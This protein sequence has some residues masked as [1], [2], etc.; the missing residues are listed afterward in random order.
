MKNALL[1]WGI[2]C[3]Q[4]FPV[5]SDAQDLW[6]GYENL[7]L[8]AKN[9]VVYQTYNEMV[10]DGKADELSWQQ[11]S[12][13]DNFGDIEGSRKPKPLY[14][15][16]VKMLWDKNFLYILAELTEPNIWCYYTTRDQIVF[17][18]NDFEIFIDPDRNT[19]NYYEFEVNA[20]NTLFDLF[21]PKPY[22]NGGPPD[23]S[24]NAAGFKSAVSIDGTLNDPSDVD[25]SWTVEIAIPFSS[26]DKEIEN[27]TPVDGSV[28]KIDFSR[29]EWKTEIVNGKYEKIKNVQT[30]RFLP[31]DNWVWS[32][33]GEINM[34]VPERWGMLQFT[35]NP[36]NG[37]N[38]TFQLPPEEKL[39]K[40]LW[41][42][43]Y[44]Q[45]NFRKTNGRFA[46]SLAELSVPEVVT[47]DKKQSIDLKLSTKENHFLV[48]LTTV[49]GLV[50]S[51][52]EDSFLQK[53]HL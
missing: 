6:S 42:V 39:E 26:F 24:W 35:T 33:T 21:L 53:S 46:T 16:R 17:H 43:Y 11:A 1:F 29:V 41:L 18:E 7:F 10:I 2:I 50:L 22:R 44:K 27:Q 40:Y 23:I 25:K 19:H 9:Y 8:P 38:V 32:P 12:W 49:D 20:A 30:G 52:N 3:T 36:V 45:Q 34:H 15:T 51:L 5:F 47:I 14:P 13:T 4:L 37:K 28:W 31:E 48:E